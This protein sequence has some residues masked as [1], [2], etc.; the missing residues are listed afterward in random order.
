MYGTTQVHPLNMF[1][2]VSF[3]VALRLKTIKSYTRPTMCQGLMDWQ[4]NINSDKS[5]SLDFA[6][7]IDKFAQEKA[8]K[9]KFWLLSPGL[10]C[11]VSK[12]LT[13]IVVLIAFS[14]H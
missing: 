14:M 10:L 4:L 12:L 5:T 2:I 13:T 3:L 9:T 8:R 7:I 1:F 6:N 11:C